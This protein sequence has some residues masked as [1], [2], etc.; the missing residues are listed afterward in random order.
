MRFVSLALFALSLFA[1]PAEA[2]QSS[3]QPNQ[4]PAHLGATPTARHA[5]W[6]ADFG[7][8]DTEFSSLEI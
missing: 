7:G 1:Q 4:L 2:W 5:R 3:M 8:P 6:I